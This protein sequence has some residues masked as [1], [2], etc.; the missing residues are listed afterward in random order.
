MKKIFH[1]KGMH[2]HSCE[3]LL[4]DAIEEVAGLRVLRAD[5]EKGEIEVEAKD[6]LLFSSVPAIVSGNGYSVVSLE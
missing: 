4:K 6:A 3:I 5:H 2:C 1:I